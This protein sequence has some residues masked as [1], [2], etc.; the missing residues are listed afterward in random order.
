MLSEEEIIEGCK[1]G[2]REAQEELYKRYAGKMMGVCIRYF[3]HREEA[4]DALQE[5]FIRVFTFITSYTGKGSFEGWLKKIIVN[6]ALNTYRSNMKYLFHLNQEAMDREP[7][8]Q[9]HDPD[10]LSRDE[11]L[12]LIQNMPDGYRLVFNLYEIEGYSHKE[13][14]EMLNVSESTSKTQLM[15]ARA[16]LQKKVSVLL[17][18]TQTI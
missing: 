15:K 2:Q 6:T 8:S 3:T 16:Y 5:G 14:A 11:L 7:N 9:H 17:N 18:E 13:I 12:K 4:E 10:T 1:K